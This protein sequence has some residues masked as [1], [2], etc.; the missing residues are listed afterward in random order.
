MDNFRRIQMASSKSNETFTTKDVIPIKLSWKNIS[1]SVRCKYSWR[2]K[3]RMKPEDLVPE[4]KILHNESGYVSQG[5][6][7]FIMGASGA[8]KT[9]L[10]NILCDRVKRDRDSTIKGQVL[11]NDKLNVT[12]QNFGKYGAYVMQDDILF[13]SFT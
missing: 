9:S 7:L 11:V 4:R 13:P 2:D 3:R 8:G 12:K 5:E 6:T 10:L 1:Y